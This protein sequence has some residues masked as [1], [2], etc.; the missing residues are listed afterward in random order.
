MSRQAQISRKTAE[1][2]IA[3]SLDLDGNGQGA[4]DTGVG[5][6]D[7]ML[8]LFARHAGMDLTVRCA[9]D[10]RVDCHHTV[11]DVGLCLGEA[12]RAAL[13]DKRSIAR[14]GTYYVPMDESLSRVS[15]DLSGR[16]YLFSTRTCR[17]GGW[18]VRYRNGGGFFSG[19]VQCR[20]RDA[21]YPVVVR[22]NT[23][24][25]LEGIFKA[26][27]RAMGKACAID[28]RMQG[29]PSTKGSL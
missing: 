3:L 4:I 2:D 22:R 25:I 13:G 10:T 24:H 5:F 8:A 12:L 15:V 9:G 23:H 28:P 17:P 1:T 19:G 7:H 14:F 16:P 20:R 18:G 27:E 6:L 11:E 26:F 21:A 29:I